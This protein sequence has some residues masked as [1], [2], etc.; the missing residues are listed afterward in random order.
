M[1]QIMETINSVPLPSLLKLLHLKIR[2][3]FSEVQRWREIL[4]E[5]QEKV[6]WHRNCTDLS[7]KFKH[8]HKPPV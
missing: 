4:D 6:L 7:V 1:S 5:A 2:V 8:V 3:I